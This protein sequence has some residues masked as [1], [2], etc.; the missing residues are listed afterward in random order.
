MT[1][2]LLSKDPLTG[3]ERWFEY[4]SVTKTCQIRTLQNVEDILN[5]NKA[6]ATHNDGYDK[7]REFRRVASI[8]V[9]LQH[10]WLAEEGI[11]V[12]NKDHWD[13][14]AKKLDSNEY[15]YLRTAPGRLGKRSRHI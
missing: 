3:I 9:T 1:K 14:V 11:D 15:A 13:A 12:Y 8:P 7:R 2:R 4:D 10:Q 6:L 5:H